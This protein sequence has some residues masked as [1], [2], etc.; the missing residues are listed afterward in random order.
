MPA[1]RPQ[2]PPH[3]F[4]ETSAADRKAL[5]EYERFAERRRALAEAEGEKQIREL[6]EKARKLP[7]KP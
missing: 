5:D 1:G 4:Y 2:V 7:K 3:T 6:E